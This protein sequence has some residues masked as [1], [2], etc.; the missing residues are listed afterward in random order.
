MR[1]TEIF[2][3]QFTQFLPQFVFWKDASSIYLGC[4]QR[5]AELV[6]LSSPDAIVGK[7]DNDLPWQ[8]SGD[9]AVFF[10]Q[11]DLVLTRQWPPAGFILDGV[12]ATVP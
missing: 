10:R 6:G 7:S 8:P 9:T 4:N 11:G 12:E 1:I 2:L 3:K 5:Y